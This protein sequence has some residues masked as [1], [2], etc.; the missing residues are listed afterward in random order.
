M[1][2]WQASGIVKATNANPMAL[3]ASCCALH[4]E[5]EGEKRE[6]RERERESDEWKIHKSIEFAFDTFCPGPMF[7][8]FT[9]AIITT[10][11]EQRT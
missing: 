2:R 3:T 9:Y 8:I 6:R 1:L 7:T 4:R 5:R 10:N 11:A